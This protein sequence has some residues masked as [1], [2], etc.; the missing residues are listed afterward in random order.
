MQTLRR[1]DSVES[2]EMTEEGMG[3]IEKLTLNC[4][5]KGNV[6]MTNWS[7]DADKGSFIESLG[8]KSLDFA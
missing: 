6:L 4:I 7:H 3:P 1:L 8:M 5:A 2:D